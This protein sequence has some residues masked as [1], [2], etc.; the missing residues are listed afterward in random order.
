MESAIKNPHSMGDDAVVREESKDN[1]GINEPGVS[2]T[3]GLASVSPEMSKTEQL[4]AKVAFLTEKLRLADAKNEPAR[5]RYSRDNGRQNDGKTRED[6][7][8]DRGNRQDGARY[9]DQILSNGKY[10]NRN[11]FDWRLHLYQSR[12]EGRLPI[13]SRGNW[14]IECDTNGDDCPGCNPYDDGGSGGYWVEPCRKP[15][16]RE[17]VKRKRSTSPPLDKGQDIVKKTVSNCL[18]IENFRPMIENLRKNSD[19]KNQ[20]KIFPMKQYC[21]ETVLLEVHECWRS[22]CYDKNIKCD[23][24]V[25]ID[26]SLADM[27]EFIA[28]W[29]GTKQNTVQN[30]SMDEEFFRRFALLKVKEKCNKDGIVIR[31]S[32]RIA[33]YH[34]QIVAL[35]MKVGYVTKDV[36]KQ[37]FLPRN[38]AVDLCK[39]IIRM[40]ERTSRMK[41]MGFGKRSVSTWTESG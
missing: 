20:R 24:N 26:L 10:I 16:R 29:D 17:Y 32:D 8:Q 4:E 2:S 28:W 14:K 18:E 6:V 34:Q 27:E 31:Y 39:D 25:V 21:N 3:T 7:Y 41:R 13:D 5:N 1:A 40:S 19:A 37:R 30:L 22:F 23:T 12:N 15:L 35:R 38:C 11:E 33:S 9:N 36:E